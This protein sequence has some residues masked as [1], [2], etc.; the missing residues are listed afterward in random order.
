MKTINWLALTLMLMGTTQG[1]TATSVEN[2]FVESELCGRLV[3]K[4]DKQNEKNKR[5]S[6]SKN[7]RKSDRRTPHQRHHEERANAQEEKGSKTEAGLKGERGPKGDKGDKGD[8]AEALSVVYGYYYKSTND[9]V[10]SKAAILF[11]ATGA[12]AGELALDTTTGALTIPE[13]G[14]YQINYFVDTLSDKDVVLG[15]QLNDDTIIP[16]SIYKAS[17]TFQYVQLQGSAI[18]KVNKDDNL[19]II[20]LSEG[21]IHFDNSA[22]SNV[23]ASLSIKKLN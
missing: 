4:Q 7:E 22:L 1:Y 17:A 8:P 6:E 18:V 10:A 9:E 15:V 20:N 11:D 5:R 2:S 21:D 23:N 12:D 3:H 13:D 16:G 19:K 14:N